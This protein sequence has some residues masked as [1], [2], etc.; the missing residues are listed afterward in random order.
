MKALL[1]LAAGGL[2]LLTSISLPV[3]GQ[4]Q[5]SDALEARVAALEQELGTLQEENAQLL[6]RLD[7][8]Q[9]YLQAQANAAAK[10][11]ETLDQSEA[12]GFTKGINYQSRETLLAGFRAFWKGVGTGVPKATAA[13]DEEE[14]KDPRATRGR[15]R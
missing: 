6:A 1:T 14:A 8:T 15:R 5:D 4:T 2:F 3:Q 12:E 10:M 9:A 7:K 13:K 11:L